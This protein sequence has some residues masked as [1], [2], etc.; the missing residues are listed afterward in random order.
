MA[1]AIAPEPVPLSKGD[2]DVW[3]IAGSRVTLDT[4]TAEF[5]RGDGT[6]AGFRT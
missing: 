1:L 4:V 6:A 3:R 5:G 2:D